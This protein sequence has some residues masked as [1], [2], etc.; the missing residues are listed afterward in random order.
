MISPGMFVTGGV[1]SGKSDFAQAWAERAAADRLYVAT[2]RDTDGE[3]AERIRLHRERRG[4][5]WTCA[6]VPIRLPEF[7]RE[8]CASSGR[9]GAILVDCLGLWISNLLA[10]G[11][12]SAAV[13]ARADDLAAWMRDDPR[14]PP[15]AVVS[16]ECGLGLLPMSPLARTY[17]DLLGQANQR[18]AR[19]C[20][21]A[22]LVA[23]GLPL[24]L[25]GGVDGGRMS[26]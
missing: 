10:D 26:S 17:V 2:C 20:E 5:G 21:N 23:S 22:V 11:L 19:A 4:E 8:L 7:L 9:P 14:R 16:Q 1:R 15:T 12:D 3:M 25:R 6:E 18:L 24:V 13:L